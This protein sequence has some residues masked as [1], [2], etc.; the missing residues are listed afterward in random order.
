MKTKRAGCAAI[1]AIFAAALAILIIEIETAHRAE[2]RLS[3]LVRKRA[4]LRAA[5]AQAGSLAARQEKDEERLQTALGTARAAFIGRIKTAESTGQQRQRAET[6]RAWLELKYGPLYRKLG[7]S[8][9]Q[10]EAL[11]NIAAAHWM[12]WRDT[13]AVSRAEGITMSDPAIGALRKQE[14]AQYQAEETELIGQSGTEQVQEYERSAAVRS[15][16]NGL[17]G[18]VYS[19]GAP[20]NAEQG[21]Q[22]TQILADGSASHQN[23]GPANV[24]DIDLDAINAKAQG[25]LSPAQFAALK[26]SYQAEQAFETL[27]HL[28]AQARQNHPGTQA[29]VLGAVK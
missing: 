7:L 9:E 17:A 20:M 28:I 6:L 8:Q 29:Q 14:D 10:I 15:L 16:A 24:E 25:V 11:E 23:G 21:E 12:R 18:I 26:E 3:A 22:L 13:L 2:A 1:M 4:G 27:N 19:I 5:L